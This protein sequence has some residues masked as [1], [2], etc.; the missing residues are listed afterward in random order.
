MKQIVV[1]GAGKIGSTIA[2]NLA[3]TGDYQ[4]T[5][6]DREAPA[7]GAATAPC[8]ARVVLDVTARAA[9]VA[10]LTGKFAVMSAAPF[11]LTTV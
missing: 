3:R 1:I 9:T 6:A 7:G 2:D 10:L 4:V 8:I 11:H 5:L